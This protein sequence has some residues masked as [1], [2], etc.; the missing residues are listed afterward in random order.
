MNWGQYSVKTP[1]RVTTRGYNSEDGA[2]GASLKEE[3]A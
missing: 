1:M 2:R 3:E